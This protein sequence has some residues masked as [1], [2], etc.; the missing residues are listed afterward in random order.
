MRDK[1]GILFQSHLNHRKVLYD[2]NFYIREQFTQI[3]NKINNKKNDNH[4]KIIDRYVD[5]IESIPSESLKNY[6]IDTICDIQFYT[7]YLGYD[8]NSTLEDIFYILY[9]TE[10]LL[11]VE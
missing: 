10:Q 7:N 5:W 4:K 9:T 11:P 3:I 6:V 8:S 1:I 2:N